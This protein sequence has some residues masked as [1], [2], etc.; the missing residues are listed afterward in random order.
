MNDHVKDYFVPGKWVLAGEHAVLRGGSA[1]ALPH[2]QWGIRAT[3]G[4]PG[5]SD[6]SVADTR[7]TQ[8]LLQLV[9]ELSSAPAPDALTELRVHTTLPK[10]GG[11]GSSAALCVLAARIVGLSDP[12]AVQ[13]QSTRL[14]NRF[15]GK[16]SG[17]D[18]AA[19][20]AAGPIFFKMGQPPQLLHPGWDLNVYVSFHDTRLRSPTRTAIAQ[21]Q[22]MGDQIGEG[23]ALMAQA[24]TQA[25]A[26]LS[27]PVTLG[28]E[29]TAQSMVL[30][31]EAYRRWGLIPDAIEQQAQSLKS[32]G[33][34]GVRLTGAGLGGFLVAL[35]PHPR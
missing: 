5:E 29:R 7:L 3:W 21:V 19:V 22:K 2:P 33:A 13:E 18:V 27:E 23:D 9:R 11:L 8:V 34:L 17:M 24:T 4:A 10:G 26:A 20:A 31:M 15:H 25:L 1:I 6:A 30:S 32:Q 12:A 35:W 28:L 14:E 16:S